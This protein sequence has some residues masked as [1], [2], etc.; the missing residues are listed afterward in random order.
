LAEIHH[1]GYAVADLEASTAWAAEALGAG[2]FF[3]ISHM[4]IDD[5]LM[6]GREVEFDHSS[7]FG[8]CGGLMIEYSEL[9]PGTDPALAA[10]MVGPGGTPAVSHVAWLVD[11]IDAE[12]ERLGAAGSECFYRSSTGPASAAWFDARAQLG[13]CIEIL[14]RS[15]GLTEFYEFLRA[16][17]EGW[18]GREPLRPYA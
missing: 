12:V 10:A 11:D 14:R 15:A 17:A 1:Y 4:K 16:Q 5:S 2:P 8:F 13:H 18:D 6:R 3:E 9:H 7:A